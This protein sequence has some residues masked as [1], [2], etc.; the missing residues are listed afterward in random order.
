MAH[1]DAMP[2]GPD[3]GKGVALASVPASGVLAGHV[4]GEP[5]LLA[6]LD[7]G[8]FAVA[9]ACTHY[10]GPL[11]QGR[12]VDGEVHCPWH[13]ACFS[14]RT[15]AA[16]KAPAFAALATYDVNIVGETVFVRAKPEST[17]PTAPSPVASISPAWSPSADER[18]KRIVI[19]G[20]GAA[21]FAAAVRLRELGHA[22]ALTM[23]SDDAAGPYDRPNLSKD[24]LAGTA[25]EDWIPLQGAAFYSDRGI[26]LRL[27]CEVAAID[28]ASRAVRT[29]AGESF[30][31]DALLIATGAEPRRLQRPG[32]DLPNVFT[33]RS[34]ADA[35]AII[36]ACGNATSVVVVGAGFIG[37]EVAGALR[38]RGLDVH[39]V[40]PEDV[41]MA[42]ALGRELG[43]F[44]AGLHTAQGVVLH[45]GAT[46]LGFDGTL[47]TLDNGERIHADLVIVGMGVEPRTQLAAAAGLAVQDG[48]L[49]D[50]QLQ[51]S[52]PGHY[53]AGDVARYR[54]GEDRLRVEHWVHAQRQG[55]RAAANMLGAAQRFDDVPFFWTHHYGLDLRYCGHAGH[56]DEV[57]IT[58]SLPDRDFTA[59]FL[60]GG[61]LVAAATVGRDQENLAIEAEL[62]R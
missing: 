41:P 31:Y 18:R 26:D 60:R 58:G 17:Q 14:L 32:F 30:A 24:Y 42:R 8:L 29:R 55:Q 33:L 40:A 48:I 56:W 47:L 1:S 44:I 34:L 2:P 5:V 27:E 39:V 10:G 51:A 9:G 20:G 16:L 43:G 22:G 52:V 3:L 37:M 61:A 62:G 21:G 23:L 45:L 11:A 12:V 28:T 15:G 38:A 50:A 35:R 46:A 25:P 4:D 53:A 49:V 13:H 6:R 54:H 57:R 7:D 59:R 19:V 36:A